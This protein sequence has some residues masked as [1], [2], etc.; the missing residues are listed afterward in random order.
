MKTTKSWTMMALGALLLGSGCDA[1]LEPEVPQQETERLAEARQGLVTE[2]RTLSWA[3]LSPNKHC[4]FGD[5][6]LNNQAPRN[7]YASG[8][9]E[10]PITLT[11]LA[12][13]RIVSLKLTNNDPNFKYDDVL[14]LAYNSQL[15]MSSDRRAAQYSANTSTLGTAPVSYSWRNILNKDISNQGLLPPW[16]TSGAT[17]CTVPETEVNGALNVDIPNFRAV[18]EAAYPSAPDARVFKLVTIGDNDDGTYNSGF[19]SSDT[20]CVHGA[21]TVTVTIT[22]EPAPCTPGS[23]PL[24]PSG[25]L[26]YG[27]DLLQDGDLM[28]AYVYNSGP[29]DTSPAAISTST[30]VPNSSFGSQ[31]RQVKTGT[32]M[33]GGYTYGG[34]Y[35]VIDATRMQAGRR[36]MMSYY[37]KS[38]SPGSY[39][40]RMS[41]QNGNGDENTMTHSVYVTQSWQYI[42]HVFTLDAPKYNLYQYAH[43]ACWTVAP[44][45]KTYLIDGMRIEPVL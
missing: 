11:G 36:Y 42:Q 17:S 26:G 45:N 14:L 29:G 33:N 5:T 4:A 43:D 1:N 37:I 8:R 12:G 23:P 44:A 18:D 22:H 31:S 7:E 10:E 34:S 16:C 30:D 20:D 27:A 39:M 32:V 13:R 3:Q 24:N 21:L 35:R 28:P 41:N 25:A 2:T 6:A 38:L 15:V 9:K 19:Q 40:V